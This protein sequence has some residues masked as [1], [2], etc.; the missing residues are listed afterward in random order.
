MLDHPVLRVDLAQRS[1]GDE[2]AHEFVVLH[3]PDW[4]NVVPITSHGQVVL[5]RQWRHGIA[6]EALEIP[7][8][9]IDPG[10][11]PMIAGARELAE[12]TGYEPKRMEP[13]GWVHPNPALFSN[14][15]YT[16]LALDCHE[17]GPP[18]PED[19]EQIQVELRPLDQVPQLIRS[20]EISHSLVVAAF[21]RYWL[22]HGGLAQASELL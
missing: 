15:C 6:E 22:E 18:R 3:S 17:A 9:I 8:G 5:I 13:L 2:P 20:G 10:E 21:T 12:E 7:G 4:V 11:T 16:C 1:L 19:T 14:R